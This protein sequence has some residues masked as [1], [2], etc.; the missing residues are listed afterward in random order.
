[1]A[2]ERQQRAARAEQMRKEREKSSRRQRNLISVAIVMVVVALIAV[3]AWAVSNAGGD[4]P[5]NGPVAPKNATSDFG[6]VYDG[7][8]EP[9]ATKPVS[10]ELYEDFQCPICQLFEQQSK[11]LLDGLVAKGEITITYRPFSFL[12]GRG[13]PNEYSHRSTNLALCALDQGGV[14]DY[15]KVHDYLYENQ[16]PEQTNGPED[17]ELLKAAEGLGIPGLKSCVDG[18]T[19]FRWIDKA[20]G[21]GDDRGVQGTPAVFVNGKPVATP[22][23]L[24]DL[25]QAINDAKNG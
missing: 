2:N 14:D 21:A 15:R 12:D 4:D 16:P 8:A 20:K 6:I 10:V 24:A 5:P 3:A 19:F 1:M 7:G 9:A 13:S 18:E 17:P 23:V 22:M 25:Q 11:A